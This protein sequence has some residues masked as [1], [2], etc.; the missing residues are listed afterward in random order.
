MN[1]C[2]KDWS[3][4]ITCGIIHQNEKGQTDD[5]MTVV[6]IFRTNKTKRH[7][8]LIPGDLTHHFTLIKKNN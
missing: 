4:S 1:N 3:Q 8:M 6:E 7:D 5:Y 2:F